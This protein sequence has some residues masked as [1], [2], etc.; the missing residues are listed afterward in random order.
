V[1]SKVLLE[2]RNVLNCRRDVAKPE[3]PLWG[4]K[5]LV[6]G[7]TATKAVAAIWSFMI[8]VQEERGCGFVLLDAADL[9]E[10]DDAVG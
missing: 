7:T 6:S 5:A 3:M 8:I 1:V 10:E 9:E 2:G 4:I